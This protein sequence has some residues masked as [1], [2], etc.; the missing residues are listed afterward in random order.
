MKYRTRALLG[1]ALVFAAGFQTNRSFAEAQGPD[2]SVTTLKSLYDKVSEKVALTYFGIYRGASVSD[3]SNSLQPGVDGTP[4]PKSPQSIESYVTTG[5]KIDKDWMAGVATHFYYFPV[6]SPAGSGQGVQMLDPSLVVSRAN[7][8]DSGGLKL[9]GLV[10]AALP[11]T[12][13][14][15]LRPRNYLTSISPTI[16]ASY[17]VPRSKL[18]LGLYSFLTAYIPSSSTNDDARTYKLCASPYA[19]YGLSKSVSA[20]LWV[21]LVQVTRNGGTGLVSGMDNA[22]MDIEP[23]INWDVTKYLSINPILNFYPSN[24]T[25]AATSIQAVIVSKVF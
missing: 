4:D 5:Y 3:P 15:Y 1:T 11:L 14:D 10:Y 24:P 19:S 13:S 21:D 22:P 2:Q 9:K 7:L 16:I 6:G 20:T 8:I 25:L 18:S 17:D 12:S 23:G